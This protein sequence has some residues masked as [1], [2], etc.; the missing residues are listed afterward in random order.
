MVYFDK[1]EKGIIKLSNKVRITDPCYD[2]NVWCA[3]TLDNVLSG[4]YECYLQ[5]VNDD[6]WGIRVANI[7]VRHQKYLNV[8]PTEYIA[9]LEVG[10]DSGQCGIFDFYMYQDICMDE[11]K[12]NDFYDTVCNLTFDDPE[13]LNESYVPFEK[14]PYFKKEFRTLVNFSH[15][16]LIEAFGNTKKSIKF[17]EN[18]EYLS[19]NEKNILKNLI[20]TNKLYEDCVIALCAYKA[21]FKYSKKTRTDYIF[22]G[23]PINEKGFVSSS[24]CGDGVYAC[25][26][27]KNKNGQ[28]VSIKIDYFPDYD[29]LA[30]IENAGRENEK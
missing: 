5:Q 27:G 19:Q 16:Q 21:D 4:N 26:I 28:I 29:K 24:G 1:E 30:E 15:E 2:M 9:D 7:E 18:K 25:F 11:Q 22:T 6:D 14:S 10:V 17:Y 13:I 12:S 8:E 3:G 23:N 20:A